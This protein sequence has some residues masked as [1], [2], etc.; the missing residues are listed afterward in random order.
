[1]TMGRHPSLPTSDDKA[2]I[3]LQFADGSIGAVHYLANGGK[4]FPKERLE[5]FCNDSV[6]VLDNYIRLRGYGW[7]GFSSQRLWRQDKGQ[8][9][10]A[11]AFVSA[12][13][14]REPPIPIEE[15]LEVSRLVIEL[16]ER[17]R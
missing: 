3:T 6:L 11:A 1:M 12:V 14:H 17:G 10:C 9:A 4:H 16:A 7:K 13:R 8:T 2:S 5:V 15:I